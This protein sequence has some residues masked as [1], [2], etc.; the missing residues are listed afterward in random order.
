[1]RKKAFTLIEI[2]IVIFVFGVGILAVLNVLTKSLGYFDAISMKT[3]ATLL[4]KEGME[5]AY[6]IRDSNIEQGYPRNYFGFEDKKERYLWEEQYK[7]FKIWFSPNENYRFFEKE[8]KNWD[9]E[10]NFK[11]FYLELSTGAQNEE[12]SYYHPVPQAELPV[13]GFARIIEYRPIK[14][15]D[16]KKWN[17]NKIL[18]ISSRVLYK[19]WASTGEVL[20]ESFIGMKD[21]LPPEN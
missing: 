3:K 17:N 20:L 5:I 8:E 6:T 21:S 2:L 12:I 1:M 10:S 14:I 19:R 15:N 13:K 9:F 18:K 16:G 11:T 7:N 4:A